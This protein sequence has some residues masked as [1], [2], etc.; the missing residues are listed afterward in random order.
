MTKIILTTIGGMVIGS[1]TGYYVV[2]WLAYLDRSGDCM[3]RLMAWI[4]GLSLGAPLG[5]ITFG[6]I[7]FGIGY[8]LDKM[9]KQ[10]Q[11]DDEKA[12]ELEA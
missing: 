6:L 8:L 11:L 4:R 5:A 7:G 2:Y 12:S 1:V 10:R 3:W 9:A